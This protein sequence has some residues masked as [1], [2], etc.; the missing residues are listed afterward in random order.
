MGHIIDLFRNKNA[1]MVYLSDHGE[2]IYDYRDSKGRKA[3][4]KANLKEW[5]NGLLEIPFL[6]WCS[7]IY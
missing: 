2:E 5:L 6:V 3:A 1:V 4:D 7:D